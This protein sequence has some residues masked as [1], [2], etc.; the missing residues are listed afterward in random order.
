M[1]DRFTDH[2]RKTMGHARREAQRLRHDY[3]GDEHMLLGMLQLD[4]GTGLDVLR[5][6]DVDIEALRERVEGQVTPGTTIIRPGQLPFTPR[7]KL[8][9]EL[10]YEEA[11]ALGHNYIGT[12]HL[13][14]GI[15]REA[16]GIA[17]QE[18]RATRLRLQ[19]VREEILELVD[20]RSAEVAT[21][22]AIGLEDEAFP[23]NARTAVSE[24]LAEA[25]ITRAQTGSWPHVF[26]VFQPGQDIERWFA[27]GAAT[28]VAIPLIL[29]V[30]DREDPHPLLQPHA[31]IV[32][33]DENFK[34][35]FR[36]AL[37]G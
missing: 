23:R 22:R 3:I 11:V 25:G 5:N 24:V 36:R 37:F 10:G 20:E 12:E 8:V 14:L 18:L 27:L 19:D 29:I 30:E 21:F 28:A 31:R 26:L 2:A 15:L 13:L 16:S 4:G 6:L 33:I 35:S 1:F 34:E 32:R 7:G 9:L 17:A